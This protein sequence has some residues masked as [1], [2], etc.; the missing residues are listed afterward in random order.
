MEIE[1][2]SSAGILLWIDSQF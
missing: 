2:L 1:R